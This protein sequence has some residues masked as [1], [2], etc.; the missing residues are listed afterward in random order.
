M[1]TIERKTIVRLF[2]RQEVE[3]WDVRN[4]ENMADVF[5]V[6]LTEVQ[7]VVEKFLAQ[8]EQEEMDRKFLG[9]MEGVKDV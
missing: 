8:I 4:T 7:Y 3:G 2:S 5:C 1:V 9:N 6:S